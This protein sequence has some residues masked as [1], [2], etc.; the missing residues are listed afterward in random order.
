MKSPQRKPSTSN[1]E[2]NMLLYFIRISDKSWVQNYAKVAFSDELEMQLW[3]RRCIGIET[4][5]GWSE[6]QYSMQRSS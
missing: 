1:E 2:L 3:S 4:G 6:M 5:P